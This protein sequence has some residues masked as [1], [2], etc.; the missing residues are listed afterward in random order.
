M[1][2]SRAGALDLMPPPRPTRRSNFTTKTKDG[3]LDKKEL[4]A[5]PG[6]LA[7]LKVYDTDGNGKISRE[8]LSSRIASWKTT[9]ASPV[10]RRYARHVGWQT[11]GRRI[12][13]IRARALSP[14]RS[15]SGH[16]ETGENGTTT[17]SIAPE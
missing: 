14:R 15:S 3:E 16:G 7:A 12:D 13:S 4:E 1:D 10:D 17:I 2:A 9:S 8:E 6:L 5:C 11:T